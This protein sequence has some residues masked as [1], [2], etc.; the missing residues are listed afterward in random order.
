MSNKK[1]VIIGS[2]PGGYVAAIRASQL[3]AD[4]IVIEKDKI[5]GTCLNYGC[6]PTKS[7]LAS[8]ELFSS[9]RKAKEFGISIG[10]LSIDLS[11]IMERKNRVVQGLGS[12]FNRIFKKSGVRFINGTA[13]LISPKRVRVK[14]PSATEEIEASS[15]VIATGSQ[16]A[17][18]PFVDLGQPTV[19]TSADALKL[20]RL[21]NSVLITG[22][23]AIG[24]EFACFFNALGVQVTLVEVMD[25]ILPNGDKRIARQMAQILKKRGVKILVKTGVKKVLSYK[26][27]EITCLLGNGEKLTTEKLLISV[28][29]K[30]N[31]QGIGLENIGV[32][33]DEKENISV[34]ENMETN[35][36][37]IY[38]IGDVI[39]GML[40]AH[41]ASAEG[42]LAVEN[43]MGIKKKI[44]YS[45]IPSCVYTFPEIAG[46]GQTADQA[47]ASGR[48]V[49]T[50]WFPFSASGK[51]SAMGQT[52]GSVQLVVD[53]GTEKILGGRIIGPHATELIH[54][55]VLAMKSG[56]TA[57]ELGA[58]THAHPT[59]SE[60]VMEA[61]LSV[62][63]EAIHVL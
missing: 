10:E 40:L 21:P 18:L 51:A 23:G 7:L 45:L 33:V 49:K 2:G 16:P 46:V 58:T 44:D 14:L 37:G 41:V 47:S 8:A 11:G 48:E 15:I 3:G 52:V 53:K 5:G 6:I 39:G 38:A 19:L 22:G 62:Y 59:L 31:S 20:K 13:N 17:S 30:P 28:G 36:K 29:R 4:V 12:G 35:I 42:I 57:K 56:M 63:K 25:Q 55:V 50:G 43:A 60:G 54:E 24:L 61:A 26:S 34:D 32:K 1:I 27:E 9:I